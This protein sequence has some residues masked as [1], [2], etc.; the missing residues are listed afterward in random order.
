MRARNQSYAADT[1]FLNPLDLKNAALMFH[2]IAALQKP[3]STIHPCESSTPCRRKVT[4]PRHPPRNICELESAFWR[5]WLVWQGSA[6]RTDIPVCLSLVRKTSKQV[7]DLDS[8]RGISRLQLS[9]AQ[10]PPSCR[11]SQAL[12]D[13]APAPFRSA[14]EDGHLARSGSNSQA[15]PKRLAAFAARHILLGRFLEI[16]RFRMPEVACEPLR[17]KV[18]A[19]CLRQHG[20]DAI[21]VRRRQA[22]TRRAA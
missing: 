13:R 12:A 19:K 2:L 21:T 14:I 22:S 5:R 17:M 18:C 8:S 7:Y 9:R 15:H 16:G 1:A 4:G 11:H 20:A 6:S 3:P 10:L